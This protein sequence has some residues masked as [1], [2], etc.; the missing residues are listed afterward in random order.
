MPAGTALSLD[1][2]P[3]VPPPPPLDDQTPLPPSDSA[4][5][6]HSASAPAGNGPPGFTPDLHLGRSGPPGFPPQQQDHSSSQ[7]DAFATAAVRASG[8][9]L[10][11]PPG[12]TAMDLVE[13]RDAAEEAR[14]YDVDRPARVNPGQQ[15]QGRANLGDRSKRSMSSSSSKP[16]KSLQPSADD[17]T[18]EGSKA[19]DRA[20]T[21]EEDIFGDMPSKDPPVEVTASAFLGID[22][23]MTAGESRAHAASTH[24]QKGQSQ[25]EKQPVKNAL[26]KIGNSTGLFAEATNESR[27]FSDSDDS[28]V[29]DEIRPASPPIKGGNAWLG[30]G[31]E[32][33]S[34]S[35]SLS[36]S[37]ASSLPATAGQPVPLPRTSTE[38]VGAKAGNGDAKP[39]KPQSYSW[40]LGAKPAPSNKVVSNDSHSSLT[41]SA[42]PPQ[43]P[44]AGAGKSYRWQ[45]QNAGTKTRQPL[46]E[47]RAALSD[48]HKAP[49]GPKNLTWR[50]TTPASAPQPSLRQNPATQRPLQQAAMSTSLAE[51]EPPPWLA[52]SGGSAVLQPQGFQTQPEHVI[53]CTGHINPVWQAI[54]QFSPSSY[55]LCTQTAPKQ[56][57]A[58]YLS[59][60]MKGPR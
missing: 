48:Q 35:S 47:K 49:G 40:K 22:S 36:K 6:K 7:P 59:M 32:P 16:P 58:E 50:R 29:L 14:L 31:E 21:R 23:N 27:D 9:G 3:S 20:S 34:T 54:T 28:L 60:G 41:Q 45:L 25:P 30:Q 2:A 26:G 46:P 13:A 42:V 44:T 33:Q 53:A 12:T 15:P 52:Q 19:G 17:Q 18:K 43:N 1:R 4:I 10:P 38:T 57:Y 51:A 11:M 56:S 5:P 55:K 37:G 39:A 8:G 24:N